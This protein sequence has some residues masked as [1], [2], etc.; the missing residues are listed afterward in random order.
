MVDLL[1]SGCE[2][3]ELPP[4][5]EEDG[6][7]EDVLC[8]LIAWLFA[9]ILFTSNMI[10]RVIITALTIAIVMLKLLEVAEIARYNS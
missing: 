1:C 3:L 4:W 9:Y 7:D 10:L 2:E 5:C 6:P 8:L